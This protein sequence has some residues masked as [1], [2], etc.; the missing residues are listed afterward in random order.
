[1]SDPSAPL[2]K[3]VVARLKA[4]GTGAGTRI[5]DMVPPGALFPYI[6]IGE[7]QSIGRYADCYDASESF[8][9]IHIWSREP[10]FGE[11]KTI[12][13]QVRLSLHD[14][15]LVLDGHTLE[16]IEF[17]DARTLRDPDGLTSHVA[18][19]FRALSQ[20]ST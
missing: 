11:A 19:T 7:A 18:A 10:N 5:Y 1:M 16:L 2:Q 14:A 4:A 15:P 13:A 8:L 3:A 12:L 20:P 9:D 6:S 17:R